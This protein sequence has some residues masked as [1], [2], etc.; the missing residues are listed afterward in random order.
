MKITPEIINIISDMKRYFN[1]KIIGS[2]L[3]VEKELLDPEDIN[4]I[5]IMVSVNFEKQLYNYLSDKGFKQT[6]TRGE[7]IGYEKGN[8][9]FEQIP[10]GNFTNKEFRIDVVVGE[11]NIYNINVLLGRKMER[12]LDKDYRQILKIVSNKLGIDIKNLQHFKDSSIG[13]YCTDKNPES[14]SKDDF[15]QLT[16]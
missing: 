11:E 4:D 1:A 9:I 6:F 10:D 16:N 5:D 13:L 2:Y 3:L 15:F 14:A 7:Q 12:G 8:A